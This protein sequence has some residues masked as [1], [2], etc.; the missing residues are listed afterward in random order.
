MPVLPDDPNHP[1]HYG[2]DQWLSATNYIEMN[3]L[4]TH[5]G[6]IVYLEG[7]SSLLMVDAALKFIEKH[8][9]QPFFAVIWYG[10]P[11]FPY[12]ALEEDTDRIVE[13]FGPEGG[14]IVR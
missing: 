8:K 10:S 9:A 1:G 14:P 7:E 12:T 6:E 4:M 11:H 3:P 5:N 13:G 2:F